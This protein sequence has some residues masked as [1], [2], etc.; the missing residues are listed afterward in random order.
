MGTRLCGPC[1]EISGLPSLPGLLWVVVMSLAPPECSCVCPPSS[2]PCK[3]ATQ[4]PDREG[5]K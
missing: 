1:G 5:T 4:I 2:D 3:L